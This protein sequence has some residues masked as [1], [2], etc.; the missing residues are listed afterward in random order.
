MTYQDLI[1]SEKQAALKAQAEAA[2]AKALYQ[3]YKN[4]LQI[5][6]CEANDRAIISY[7]NGD[8][9]TLAEFTRSYQDDPSFRNRLAHRTLE[10]VDRQAAKDKAAV[11]DEILSLM[12]VSPESAPSIRKDL[13]AKSIED[14]Q[15]RLAEIKAKQAMTKDQA[16]Q[17]LQQDAQRRR[18][19][20]KPKHPFLP[21]EYDAAAIKR[22]SLKK[23]KE[24]RRVYGD[25][26][27]TKRL[28]GWDTQ[29]QEQYLKSGFN[30]I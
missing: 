13:E 20:L 12:I 5:T 16:R 10:Q 27:I 25:D 7:F 4:N 6:P 11:I 1:T 17:I 29:E 24:L 9:I 22:L 23:L 8:E 18:D 30:G 2:L 28:N 21:L 19:E 15:T 26:A 14:L 3:I